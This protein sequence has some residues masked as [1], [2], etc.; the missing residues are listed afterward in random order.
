MRCLI[1]GH[2]MRTFPGKDAHRGRNYEI[3]VECGKTEFVGFNDEMDLS[4]YD[5]E[6]SIDGPFEGIA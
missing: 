2:A 3:C 6:P 5:H 4:Q 1:F